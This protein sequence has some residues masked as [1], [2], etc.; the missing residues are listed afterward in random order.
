MRRRWS[1]LLTDRESHPWKSYQRLMW[2]PAAS[3]PS[4][5]SVLNNPTVTMTG[6]VTEMPFKRKGC[7]ASGSRNSRRDGGPRSL[8]HVSSMIEIRK[9]QRNSVGVSFWHV[10]VFD[11]KCDSEH[12]A[13]KEDYESFHFQ[14]KTRTIP[15]LRLTGT[16]PQFK[17]QYFK[18]ISCI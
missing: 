2:P 13:G 10:T 12:E 9:D 11:I 16:S 1:R 14:Q 7:P 3:T 18:M 15:W 5:T 4:G 8:L 6:S 17:C